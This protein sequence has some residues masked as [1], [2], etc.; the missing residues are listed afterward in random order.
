MHG[1]GK[2]QRRVDLVGHHACPVAHHDVADPLEL[3]AAEH[4]APRVVRLGQD[5]GP[6][7]RCEHRVEP[8]E[9]D[10]GALGSGVDHEVDA[11]T[12]GHR[13]DRELR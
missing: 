11:R 10:L 8:V 5:Q 7:A 9:V 2:H 13:G 12:A 6:G 3:G 1:A 4:P